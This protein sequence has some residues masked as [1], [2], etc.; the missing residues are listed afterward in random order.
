MNLLYIWDGFNPLPE[1]RRKAIEATTALY[2]EAKRLCI[3]RQKAFLPGFEIVPW[4]NLRDSMTRHFGFR[5]PPYAW[6]NP[7]TFSDWAR[8]FWLATHGDTLYLDTDAKMLKLYA[9]GPEMVY[10]KGNI[11]LLYVPKDFDGARFLSMLGRRAKLHVGILMDFAYKFDVRWS[12]PID[13]SYFQH[14]GLA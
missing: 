3:T 8:F 11:C 4:D 13:S 7:V 14:R 5:S 10:S 12:K 6:N 1:S 9:F 2:P